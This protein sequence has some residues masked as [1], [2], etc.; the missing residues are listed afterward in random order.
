M[1][2]RVI[3]P[4][5]TSVCLQAL[6]T[7]PASLEAL[8]LAGFPNAA[9]MLSAVAQL[10]SLRLLY[11]DYLTEEQIAWIEERLPMIR[12]YDPVGKWGAMAVIP[13]A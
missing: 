6:S 2:Y 12:P 1:G 10:K 3:E 4:A 11:L 7:L 5:L 8:H 9:D 13:I